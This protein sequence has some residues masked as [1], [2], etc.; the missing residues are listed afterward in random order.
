MINYFFAKA[1]FLEETKAKSETKVLVAQSCSDSVGYS[2]H[3]IPLSVYFPG[4]NTGMGSHSLLQRIFP[5]Q[6]SRS[7]SLQADSLPS[8]PQAR[9]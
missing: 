7:P 2:L 8:E 3:Q 4:K 5:P 9:L 6:E 1:V